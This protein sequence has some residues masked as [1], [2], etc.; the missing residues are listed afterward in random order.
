MP[1]IIK[2]V[3]WKMKRLHDRRC[4][5]VSLNKEI[6]KGSVDK[7]PLI[8]N[9]KELQA[10]LGVPALLHDSEVIALQK[11]ASG[12]KE[13]IVEIGAAFGGSSLLF[14][15]AKQ[16]QA[17]V[18]SIDP[19][20]EDSMGKFQATQ[21][22]CYGHV[23]QALSDIGFEKR[24]ADWKLIPDYSYNIVK[25]WQKPIDFL[26]IDGD[27]RYEAVKQDFEEWLPHV[28]KGGLI[29]FHDSCRAEG[30]PEEKYDK[31]WPGPTKLLH[32]LR[33]DGRVE[34]VEE[35]HSLSIIRKL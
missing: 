27:H 31:G 2:R 26:F 29:A 11:Y 21:K 35:V 5:L 1:S 34:R 17:T 18:T 4:I 24:I 13:T 15:L 25:T 10:L 14:L 3:W 9:R 16:A 22:K 6:A 8:K 30:T 7:A 23:T 28:K 32:E 12:A 33:S 19:F 20:I